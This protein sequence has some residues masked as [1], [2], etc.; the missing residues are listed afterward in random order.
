MG[1]RGKEAFPLPVYKTG[2][3]KEIRRGKE[4][5]RLGEAKRLSVCKV[6]EAKRQRDWETQRGKEVFV[7]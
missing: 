4:A 5:K 7:R 3:G 2:R 1:R 6:G